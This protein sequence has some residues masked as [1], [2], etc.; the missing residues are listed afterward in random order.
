MHAQP[1]AT[2][3]HA[4]THD[5]VIWLKDRH[6]MTEPK[7]IVARMARDIVDIRQREA[8]ANLDLHLAVRGWMQSQI[9]EFAARAHARIASHEEANGHH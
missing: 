9:T 4:I 2:P 5:G 6:L 1:A 7:A 8:D 3:D